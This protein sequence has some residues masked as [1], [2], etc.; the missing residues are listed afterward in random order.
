VLD[1]LR[2][3]R[4]IALVLAVAGCAAAALAVSGALT[5]PVHAAHP[6]GGH[7]PDSAPDGDAPEAGCAC[8]CCPGQ[9]PVFL[10]Q[11]P[12]LGLGA[13]PACLHP[14]PP[15]DEL[16]PDGHVQSIFHPPRRLTPA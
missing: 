1:W 7:C 10:P 2:S 6:A 11:Q 9:A 13:L 16:Q 5:E 4:C 14:A 12:G 15:Q 3:A 8:V